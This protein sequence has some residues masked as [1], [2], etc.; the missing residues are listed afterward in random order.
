MILL[1]LELVNFRQYRNARIEL[2][3]GLVG[4]IGKNGTGKSTLFDAILLALYGE[5]PGEKEFLRYQKAGEKEPVAVTMRMLFENREYEIK[6]EFRGKNLT[7]NAQLS[8]NG[9]TVATGQKEVTAE[10]THLIGMGGDAFSRSIFAGQKELGLLSELGDADRKAFIRKILGVTRIDDVQ[11]TIRADAGKIRDE[12]TGQESMMIAPGQV[13]QKIEELTRLSAA[14][15][16]I[17]K[18]TESAEKAHENA[19]SAYTASKKNY[20]AEQKKKDEC[21]KVEALYAKLASK[22]EQLEK[23][24]ESNIRRQKEIQ[25]QGKR[26]AELETLDIEFAQFEKQLVKLEKEKEAFDQAEFLSGQIGEN[27]SEIKSMQNELAKFAS[28]FSSSND[29]VLLHKQLEENLHKA[30]SE[31]E[32][33]VASRN[34]AE[35]ALSTCR[36]ILDEREKSHATLS[37][38][39]ADSC[40]PTCLRPLGD[41]LDATLK[42]LEAERTAYTAKQ[43]ELAKLAA[44]ACKTLADISEQEKFLREKHQNFT[45]K[46]TKLKQKQENTRQL[47]KK[48]SNMG[49]IIFRK[50]DYEKVK[51]RLIDLK[52]TH[53]EFIRLLERKKELPLLEK[54]HAALITEVEDTSNQIKKT[55]QEKGEIGFSEKAFQTAFVSMQE[56]EMAKDQAA[57]ELS[58]LKD[59]LK[60]NRHMHSVLEKDLSE[61]EKRRN[62]I[63][64]QESEALRLSKLVSLLDGFKTAILS[65]IQPQVSHYASALFS[66]LTR[67]RFESIHVDEDFRFLIHDE[68]DYFPITRFSGGEQDLANLCLRLALSSAIRD[69]EGAAAPAFLGFDEIFGSQDRERRYEILQALLLLQEQYRQILIISHDEELKDEFP[70]ILD[71]RR[72]DTGSVVRWLDV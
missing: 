9:K 46:L 71:V 57:K 20:F 28:D 18:D 64:N 43:T 68:G 51:N 6:R 22:K 23:Q 32:K 40:C 66:K 29:P 56:T 24:S 63:A 47:E 26:L 36:N 39:G 60:D 16:Q 67:G 30:E 7:A 14:I 4:I 11:R 42:K 8:C 58:I 15:K 59:Q 72:T 65:K 25:A 61:N 44:K 53:E 52:Q 35:T 41:A 50:D 27:S 37:R 34:A 45:I 17:G 31:K 48:L 2:R 33:A 38:E 1:S 10:I 54:E 5:F 19:L 62:K 3:E 12:I 69:L 49:K 13:L 70:N 21:A 55:L